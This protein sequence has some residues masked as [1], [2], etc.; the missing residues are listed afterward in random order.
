MFDYQRATNGQMKHLIFRK[1]RSK[2]I[3]L[4]GTNYISCGFY[5]ETNLWSSRRHCNSLVK[6][7]YIYIFI[8]HTVFHKF[9]TC[10]IWKTCPVFCMTY[11][12]ICDT[13]TFPAIKNTCCLL[14][15]FEC[16]LSSR[17]FSLVGNLLDIAVRT[18]GSAKS[19]LWNDVMWKPT[20]AL[21]TITAHSL[22]TSADPT[23][24][25]L[26]WHDVL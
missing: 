7:V 10:I 26:Y 23:C 3:G 24:D 20:K 22:F 25:I 1:S 9:E 5:I 2:I 17:K 4:K 15:Q 21:K 16:Q 19:Q 11:A 12:V 6:Y 18:W 8:Y 13:R 14:K